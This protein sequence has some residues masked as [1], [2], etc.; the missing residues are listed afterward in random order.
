[1]T[2][3]TVNSTLTNVLEIYMAFINFEWLFYTVHSS[4]KYT[5]K[6]QWFENRVLK[7]VN[8]STFINVY[9]NVW[10]FILIFLT[11]TFRFPLMPYRVLKLFNFL[12]LAL[13]AFGMTM[14]T[15]FNQYYSILFSAIPVIGYGLFEQYGLSLYQT[16]LDTDNY[17]QFMQTFG[18]GGLCVT[19]VHGINK[20]FTLFPGSLC[21]H[22][23]FTHATFFVVH[24]IPIIYLLIVR[25]QCTDR[26]PDRI[27]VDT[28]SKS[29]KVLNYYIISFIVYF[30]LCMV[31]KFTFEYTDYIIFNGL[32]NMI[33]V[34]VS[35]INLR[36]NYT[37]PELAA[38]VIILTGIFGLWLKRYYVVGI[39]L[40]FVMFTSMIE[41][42]NTK[43]IG[44]FHENLECYYFLVINEAVVGI[45][46]YR[47]IKAIASYRSYKST[48][49]AS[50]AH[51]FDNAQEIV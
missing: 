26:L 19:A 14:F 33:Y 21:S 22:Y 35:H 36:G 7:C 45:I 23:L 44:N 47:L 1:M 46:I 34:L 39:L 30:T 49:E 40:P 3:V 29:K 4:I 8:T 10:M 15:S 24:S 17:S 32:L 6:P 16:R 2:G 18:I 51:E 42:F 9:I 50:I 28:L 11:Q 43:A 38:A 5:D 37:R 48:S 41:Y 27:R 12:I 31:L 20:C 13:F 25:P